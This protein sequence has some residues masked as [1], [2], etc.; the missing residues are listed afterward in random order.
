MTKK[1]RAKRIRKY[2]V[3]YAVT[4]SEYYEIEAADPKDAKDRAFEE[5]TLI[6]D[7]G[8]TTSVEAYDVE[9]IAS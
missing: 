1:P 4:R 3:L 7:S 2:R 8:E 6:D 5:G 9:E